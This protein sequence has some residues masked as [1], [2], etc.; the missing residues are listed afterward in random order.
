MCGILMTEARCRR[1]IIATIVSMFLL[2]LL[3]VVYN[4]KVTFY[5]YIVD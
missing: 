2:L 3:V 1:E 5:F 4:V